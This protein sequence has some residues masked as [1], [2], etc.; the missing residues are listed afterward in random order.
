MTKESE[1]GVS[2]SAI[3]YDEKEDTIET[4]QQYTVESAAQG[5]MIIKNDNEFLTVL[6]QNPYSE[7]E[8]VFALLN[9]EGNVIHEEIF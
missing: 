5:L 8:L 6:S 4:K 1:E 3:A 9:Y 7:D 2:I